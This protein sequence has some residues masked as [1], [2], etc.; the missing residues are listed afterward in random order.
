MHFH[1]IEIGTSP[2]AGM[3]QVDGGRMEENW[4]R[5]WN[6]QHQLALGATLFVVVGQVVCLCVG[7]YRMS[8]RT[9]VVYPGC[10]YAAY[11]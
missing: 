7:G 4:Q 11:R 9:G 3:L 10:R 2:F 6:Q 5:Q 1:F 8:V